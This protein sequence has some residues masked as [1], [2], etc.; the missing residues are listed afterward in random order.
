MKGRELIKSGLSLPT[1]FEDQKNA[2]VQTET[3]SESETEAEPESSDHEMFQPQSPTI[4]TSG[5]FTF[6][7]QK[8]TDLPALN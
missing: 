1:A 7:E 5:T 2:L 6:M 3:E 4:A 8:A